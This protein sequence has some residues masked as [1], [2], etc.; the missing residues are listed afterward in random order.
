MPPFSPIETGLDGEADDSGESG[1]ATGVP[2]IVICSRS[3]DLKYFVSTVSIASQE[4]NRWRLTDSCAAHSRSMTCVSS[5]AA[6]VE[7]KNESDRSARVKN[8]YMKR[9]IIL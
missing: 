7:P 8:L 6:K 3:A 5:I 1:T 2:C 4:L 9:K